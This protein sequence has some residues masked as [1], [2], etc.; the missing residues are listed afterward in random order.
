VWFGKQQHDVWDKDGAMT[1]ASDS[2]KSSTPSEAVGPGNTALHVTP[3][4]AHVS[5]MPRATAICAVLVTP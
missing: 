2:T 3:V 1:P 4:P 5:A